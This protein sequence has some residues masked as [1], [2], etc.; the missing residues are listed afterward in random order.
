MPSLQEITCLV[1]YVVLF[2][3]VGLARTS[4]Q[5]SE[6]LVEYRRTVLAQA[7]LVKYHCPLIEANHVR[8]AGFIGACTSGTMGES[9]YYI[10][11]HDA[12]EEENKDPQ[13]RII[14]SV[15]I[16]F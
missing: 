13:I 9:P 15:Q 16:T 5:Y 1:C 14:I 8:W 7:I 6:L 3:Q 10:S 12:Q 4:I 11:K 2:P